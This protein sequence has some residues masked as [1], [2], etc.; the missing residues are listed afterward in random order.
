MD[1][2]QWQTRSSAELAAL[3]E[4]PV[5]RFA[6]AVP[7]APNPEWREPLD[8]AV[9]RGEWLV[10]RTTPLRSAEL[11]RM[12]AGLRDVRATGPQAPVQVLGADPGALPRRQTLAFRRRL[13][14]ALQPD[15]LVSNLPLRVNLVVPLVY[16]G[17]MATRAAQL[18]AAEVLAMLDILE[19]A[20]LRPASLPDDVRQIAVLARAL[21]PMPELLLIEDPLSSVKSRDAE[22]AVRILRREVPTAIVTTFRRN[23]ALYAAADRL[24]T[25]D[26]RGFLMVEPEVHA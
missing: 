9:A 3:V 21:A 25:W 15:G 13:G 6:G 11:L 5:V 18:R 2:E 10:V 26:S 8:L 22:R 20:D 19:Y 24:A 23:E 14:V 17:A 16:S 12:V 1:G 7:A 4:D